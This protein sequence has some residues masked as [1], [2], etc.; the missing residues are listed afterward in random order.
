MPTMPHTSREEM[1]VRLSSHVDTTKAEHGL[2]AAY[3]RVIPT[4]L[5]PRKSLPA[6]ATVRVLELPVPAGRVKGAHR[7]S[8]GI[9][10]LPTDT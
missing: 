1:S 7:Y 2:P 10:D 6:P 5:A 8:V 3:L 9:F 4:D